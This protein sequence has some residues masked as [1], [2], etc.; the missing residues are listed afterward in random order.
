MF[1]DCDHIVQQKV[2]NWH[3]IV[4]VGVFGYLVPKPT[5]LVVSYDPN[6]TE[7]DRRGMVSVKF[8]T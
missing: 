2:E 3:I 7:E 4:H 1:V 8:C 5:Q 6:S